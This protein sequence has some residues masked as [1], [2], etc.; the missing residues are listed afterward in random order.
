[1]CG[2]GCNYCCGRKEPKTCINLVDTSLPLHLAVADENKCARSIP[3]PNQDGTSIVTFNNDT[4]KIEYSDGSS[5]H[6][7]FLPQLE[8]NQNGIIGFAGITSSGRIY[9]SHANLISSPILGGTFVCIPCG[10]EESTL[11]PGQH[12]VDNGIPFDNIIVKFQGTSNIL[13]N[14]NIRVRGAMELHPFAGGSSSGYFYTG[15]HPT[16]VYNCFALQIYTP[17][18][19]VFFNYGPSTASNQALDYFA[20]IQAYGNSFMRI[21]VTDR[22]TQ[23]D[24]VVPQP[25]V[26]D[27]DPD[28]PLNITPGFFGEWIQLD[29]YGATPA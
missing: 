10:V 19:Y 2:C 25:V 6:P 8:K 13:Y 4:N 15:G 24:I 20:T 7:I 12:F 17:F 23:S 28:H 21:F 3:D 29:V 1:M 22:D 26:P 11:S 9:N 27:D 5:A 16:T 18:S 14:I